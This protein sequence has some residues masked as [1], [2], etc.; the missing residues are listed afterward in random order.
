MERSESS[1]TGSHLDDLCAS[2]VYR[3][4]TPA[5]E[6]VA[7]P[8]KRTVEIEGEEEG[9]NSSEGRESARVKPQGASFSLSEISPL[10]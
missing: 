1:K 4:L 8:R 7:L 3:T 6:A 10:Q 5:Q 2:V 9:A